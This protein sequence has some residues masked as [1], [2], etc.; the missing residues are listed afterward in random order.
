MQNH[1]VLMFLYKHKSK[2]GGLR[3]YSPSDLIDAL[4]S[5]IIAAH[6]LGVSLPALK[7]L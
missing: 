5:G 3:M 1:T 7:L 6:V 2:K 4:V